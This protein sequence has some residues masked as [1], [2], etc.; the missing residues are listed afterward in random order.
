MFTGLI[1]ATGRIERL[2]GDDARRSVVISA[3]FAAE[4]RAGDSVAVNGVCLTV[5]RADA[6]TFGADVSRET[7]RATSF[8][9]MTA[10]RLVN[11]ERPLRA[12]ARL[13]GHFVLG[14]VDGTAA[15]AG[16]DPDGDGLWLEVE[17]PAPLEPYLVPKGSIA[18]DGISLTIALLSP[19]RM[20]IQIV[21]FT[22]R[23]TSL[24]EVR[25]GDL[26]NLEVDVLGKYVARLLAAGRR[27]AVPVR[28]LEGH[29]S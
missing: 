27:D 7:L 4:L 5:V 12:D 18:V 19:A 13:G 8:G 3:P 22:F 9:R 24:G 15:I 28:P 1:E 11:L 25:P 17:A 6:R 23:H 29:P 20:G 16:L 26:V 14:H 21:P 10:G 2:D